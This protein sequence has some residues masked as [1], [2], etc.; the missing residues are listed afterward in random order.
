MKTTAAM[1]WRAS[2]SMARMS[3]VFCSITSPILVCCRPVC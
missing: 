1:A 3:V 2:E